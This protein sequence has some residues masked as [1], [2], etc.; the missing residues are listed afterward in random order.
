M[1][2]CGYCNKRKGKRYCPS[3]DRVICSQ[4]CGENRLKNIDCPSDCKYLIHESY[5]QNLQKAKQFKELLNIVPH[6][7]DND[8]FQDDRAKTIAYFLEYF[9]ADTYVKGYFN[10]IDSHVLEALQD[11]YWARYQNKEIKLKNE[12]SEIL[13]K[14][15]DLGQKKWDEFSDRDFQGKILLRLTISIRKMTG[16]AMGPCGYLNYLK[17]NI[18]SPSGA[19]EGYC[20]VE[21]K[22]GEKKVAYVGD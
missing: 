7:K 20:I 10:L 17:N 13:D 14:V 5:Q 1:A 18:Y 21:D 4:C 15:I 12:F 9:F 6:G 8:I 2:K 22:Y 3:L 11:V 19:P 16:G